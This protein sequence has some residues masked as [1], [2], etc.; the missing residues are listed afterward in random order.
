M[1]REGFRNSTGGGRVTAE[2]A[3]AIP[4]ATLS[5]RVDG[6]S[7]SLLVLAT[8]SNGDLLWT[9]AS[10]VALMT[11]DGRILRS[12]GLPH[13]KGGMSGHLGV[14]LSPLTSALKAPYRSTRT[15][16]FPDI[17]Y[18]G[19]ALNCTAVARGRQL[20]TILGTALPTTKV[21]ESCESRAPRWSFTDSYWLD[22]ESGFVWQSTQNIHPS[23]TVVKIK[24]L[25]PPE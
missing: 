7:E 2:Q 9:A 22:S 18:Y 6:N 1:V 25:R 13:D 11:R 3:A 5:Y 19:V 8:D 23:G 15:A 17:G 16:D 21:E 14:P 4:Y 24:I 20:I 12:V 10:H